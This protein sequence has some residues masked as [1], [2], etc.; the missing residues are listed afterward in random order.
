MESDR[1]N[2]WFLPLHLAGLDLPS[3]VWKMIV[4]KRYFL[5]NA[6]YC[7]AC[8]RWKLE[9]R[10]CDRC[11][12]PTPHC[13]ECTNENSGGLHPCETC[14]TL[15]CSDCTELCGECSTHNCLNCLTQCES[16]NSSLCPPHMNICSM[17]DT[18]LC[19]AC[20]DTYKCSECDQIACWDHATQCGCIIVHEIICDNCDKDLCHNDAVCSSVI[21]SY[22]TAA[23]CGKMLCPRCGPDKRCDN[24]DIVYCSI[25]Q[26]EHDCNACSD[27]CNRCVTVN[28]LKRSRDK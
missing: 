4:E 16:C 10:R 2:D 23:A 11:H 28:K 26:S 5:E 13:A 14:E 27:D 1:S 3:D 17:C 25:C 7:N 21:C 6:M 22:S 20:V 9:W 15:V 12:E 8:G 24:C 19:D 18:K